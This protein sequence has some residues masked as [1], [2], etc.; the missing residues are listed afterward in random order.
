MKD[1][2]GPRTRPARLLNRGF[3]G[4]LTAATVSSTGDGVLYFA[5]GWVATAHG[6]HVAGVVLTL[7][8]LPRA[9]LVL[10]GGALGDRFGLRRTMIGCDV[11]TCV[12][13]LAFLLAAQTP[14]SE[15]YLLAGLQLA[16]GTTTA[17]R[18]PAD[19]AFPRLFFDANLLP[20][21]MSLAGGVLQ[22]ARLV[23]PPLGGVVVAALTMTGAVV[24]DLVSFVAVLAVLL[25]VRPPREV[26]VD[27][28]GESTLRQIRS[29]LA[30]ARTVPGVAPMLS[31]VAFLAATILPTLG[32]CVP[33]AGHAR[34]WSADATGLVE[35]CWVAGAL[36]MSLVIAK[37]GT[38]RRPLLPMV[39]GSL[40]TVAGLLAIAGTSGEAQAMVAAAAMGVGTT[41]FTGHVF[42][43]FVLR[44]PDGML[45]RFQ[46]LLG[47]AQFAPV[48]LAN[49]LLGGVTSAAG[50]S[51]AIALAAAI[52]VL[53]PATLLTSST[54]RRMTS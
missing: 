35:A 8:A 37:R 23:G 43:V 39:A 30:A 46:S 20:R 11:A 16:I 14:V 1:L 42:P 54:L 51:A 3:V 31:A 47:L 45:A 24:V 25:A 38:H 12:V 50:P 17:F 53:A 28:N 7:G 29:G 2:A 18:M 27:D 22:T 10:F 40:T 26:P 34:G 21:A 33:A 13:L 6:G 32:L 15:I 48:L 5:V 41:M 49:N 19:G 52:A 4:W 44:T 9:L 36:C